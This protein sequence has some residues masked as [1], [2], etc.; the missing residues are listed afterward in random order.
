MNQ[1]FSIE[2]FTSAERVSKATVVPSCFAINSET[3]KAAII[4]FLEKPAL[5][6]ITGI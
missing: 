5:C 3:L 6:K 4:P 1:F 2:E